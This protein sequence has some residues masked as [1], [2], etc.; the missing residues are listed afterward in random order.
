MS[1]PFFAFA[2]AGA[3]GIGTKLRRAIVRGQSPR[4]FATS[5]I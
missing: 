3:G 2:F 1:A 5:H 4:L